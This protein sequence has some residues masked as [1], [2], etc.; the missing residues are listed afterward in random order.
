MFEGSIQT[1]YT[2]IEVNKVSFSHP[3]IKIAPDRMTLY[4]AFCYVVQCPRG[5]FVESE[6]PPRL[7]VNRI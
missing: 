6:R 4:T 1:C 2:I 5:F 3:I 7:T